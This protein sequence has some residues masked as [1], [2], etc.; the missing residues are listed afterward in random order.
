M[1]AL[2]HLDS[3]LTHVVDMVAVAVGVV[4]SLEEWVEDDVVSR[5]R[6]IVEGYQICHRRRRRRRLR[7]CLKA[8]I[9]IL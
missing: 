8:D 7:G 9:Y 2:F 5:L 4:A 1:G 3:H 6:S